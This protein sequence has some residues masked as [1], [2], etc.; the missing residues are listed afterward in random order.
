MWTVCNLG[1]VLL[2]KFVIIPCSDA[3]MKSRKKITLS[4][5]SPCPCGSGLSIENCHFDPIDGRLR[6]EVPPLV[7]PGQ[8]TGYAHPK[9]Y[10][11]TTRNCSKQ[12]S[13][14]HYVSRSVLEKLG[15]VIEL[16]GAH[17]LDNDRTLQTSIGS[18]TAKILCRRHNESLSSLDFEA[19]LF[20]ET[21][22]DTLADLK[23][24]TLSRKSIFHLC[25]GEGIELWMLKVACGH[26]FGIGASG[27]VRL[28]QNYKIDIGKVEKAF[29][30]RKWEPRCGLYFKGTT[31]DRVITENKVRVS[32]LLD[33]QRKRITGV[34]MSL[35][36]LELDLLFESENTI[37][38]E[39]RGLIRRPTELVWQRRHRRHS[40]ILTWP[41][42]YP[43]R[44][45]R[46]DEV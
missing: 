44:S 21:L 40:I 3:A 1:E 20:F 16:S 6:R 12:I 9:C 43:E 30:D 10:L 39:W 33:E 37:P 35:L 41:M 22:A 23:R 34:S 28:D 42:G 11:S 24:K 27:G 19:G 26:Y 25:S 17:W 8:L 29:F 32:A 7:P 46:F 45:I 4:L 18:L 5:D 14:E 13:R 15:Q 2:K 36:G 38:G 31:G